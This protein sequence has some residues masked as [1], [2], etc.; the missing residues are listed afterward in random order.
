MLFA[1]LKI[2]LME[3]LRAMFVLKQASVQQLVTAEQ[4]RLAHIEAHLRLLEN[5][6]LAPEIVLTAAPAFLA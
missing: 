4:A 1:Y 6:T 5:A 3:Q 2:P